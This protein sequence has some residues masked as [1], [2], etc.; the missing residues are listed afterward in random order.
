[1]AKAIRYEYPGFDIY[2]LSKVCNENRYGVR[3]LARAR[4]LACAAIGVPGRPDRRR[5]PCRVYCR[6]SRTQYAR[7]QTAQR[8]QGYA[9][10]QD[11][12]ADIIDAW[13]LAHG[14]AQEEARF[15]LD[16]LADEVEFLTP[17]GRQE[18]ALQDGAAAG[19]PDADGFTELTA[20]DIP[21]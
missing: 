7:L 21:F 10:M 6:L 20:D 15:S 14:G 9:T 12:L 11:A 5:L 18:G 3:L 19:T 4:E 8:A 17:K 2:L 1:M 16:V 13:L